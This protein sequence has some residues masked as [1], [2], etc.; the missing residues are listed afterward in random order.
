MQHS[1]LKYINKIGC[2]LE[3]SWDNCPY[4]LIQDVSVVIDDAIY[5][6]ETNSPPLCYEDLVKWIKNNTPNKVNSTCGLHVHV[7]LHRTK[8]YIRLMEKGFN[9]FFLVYMEKWGTE[10]MKFPKKHVFWERYNSENRFCLKDFN[11]DE[12][13]NLKN[14]GNARRTHLN[15][16]YALHGTIECR[17]FPAFNK[18]DSIIK[19]VEA[20]VDCIESYLSSVKEFE[21]EKPVEICVPFD[22]TD[23]ITV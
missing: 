20:Y 7:S 13:V 16:C 15:Y 1:D 12:Q 4:D 21:D 14:K 17:L 19:C 18:S 3:G 22:T 8:D 23:L 5:E 11:P 6:G 10:T 9:S 2:E